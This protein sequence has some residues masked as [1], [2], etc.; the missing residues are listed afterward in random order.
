[1][2][3]R[4]RLALAFALLALVPLAVVVPLTLTRLRDTLSRELDARMTAATASAQE[5]LERSAANARRAVEELV[6][7]PAMEDLVREA[8]AAPLRAIQANTAE[9]LMKSRG[10]TVLT[11]FDRNGTVLSSGH[12]PAR[13]GDPD[14]VLFAVTKEK[15]PRPV[16]VR[17]DMRGDA[18]LRQV[19]ALVTARPVDY[20]D[21]RLWA[22]GGVVLDDGLAQHLAR[23]TQS[24]V[25]L[26]SGDTQVAHAGSAAPPTVE[27]V[28][29]LGN[30]A[31]VRLT[32]SRAAARE[33]EEGVMRAFLLLAGLGLGFAALLGMLVSR[34]M[35][36]PVEALTSGARRVAEGALDVQVT[37]R[38]TGE[39][40]ELV[41]TF[42]HM[43]SEL[44]NTTERLMA[45]ERIAAWQEVAR[46]LAHE[47]K[48]P[49]TP[50][51]MS[52]ETLLAAHEARHPSFPTLFK[53]SAGVILEEV[54][55]LRRIV[56]EF[57]RFARLPKPQL[58]PV[59]MGE[60]AQSV[61]SLYAAPPE[62]I[63]LEPALQ[64]GVVARAD[65]DQLTQVLVNLVKNAEEAM[66][67]K[68]GALRV[69]VKGTDADAIVEVEDEGP[70]IPP[71][72]RARIFEPYFTTKDGG[73]GL[74][75]AI[76]SR[77]LQEHGGRLEVGGEPGQGARFSVVL[78]RAS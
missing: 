66:T 65:R 6:E 55:R 57:S 1:M 67:G 68:G 64:T 26:L 24:D 9:G 3:L 76:A 78:P 75:L 62:G 63:R 70:G 35:T 14:P 46:R 45:T 2:R 41:R 39:V 38:A 47:I 12:L 53:E 72:H 21:V 34:W 37:A 13:R 43:T 23:L 8:R 15:S 69:R 5:S 33:A 20:G 56:D 61:L 36:R 40:G 18:G 32:F 29:P 30:A 73:T 31:S 48:N 44:K 52:L 27:Q 42:N 58:A 49:L 17:V 22:V 71:E 77:I 25:T 19:P 51:R 28:L 50:I 10:L 7:S 16:P 11:L 59:D 74:G 60:L 54:E 4:T